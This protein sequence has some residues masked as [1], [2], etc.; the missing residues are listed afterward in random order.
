MTTTANKSLQATRDGA[1]S[2]AVA[3]GASW[4]RVPELNRWAVSR[5][6]RRAPLIVSVGFIALGLFFTALAALHG[7]EKTAL[8]L[9]GHWFDIVWEL[10]VPCL[11]FGALI[12]ATCFLTQRHRVRRLHGQ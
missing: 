11:A 9:L 6:M 12:G 5:F 8:F 1:C 2:S 10:A 7:G 4:S 3:V